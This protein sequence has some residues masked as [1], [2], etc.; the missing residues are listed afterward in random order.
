[1]ESN[2]QSF[3]FPNIFDV[4]KGE[5]SILHNSTSVSN[6]TRLLLLTEPTEL[7]NS[8]DFGV[9]FKRHLFKYNTPNERS[10]IQDRIINQLKLHEPKVNADETAFIDGLLVS[11][12]DID[13]LN[14][15]EYNKLKMTVMLQC[16]FGDKTE[17]SLN[18]G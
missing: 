2:T 12:N 15:T 3:A 17:V 7:Y 16:I 4:A 10:I 1:M 6:R 18:N 13:E 9:G 8:P 5:V 11:S 14:Y